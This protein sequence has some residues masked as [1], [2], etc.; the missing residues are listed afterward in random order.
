MATEAPAAPAA[1]PAAAPAAPPAPTTEIHVTPAAVDRGPTAP[2]PKSGSARERMFSDLRKKAGEEPDTPP[3]AT[4]KPKVEPDEAPGNEPTPG[5]EPAEAP[6]AGTPPAELAKKG[7]VS[8]WKLVEEHK[9]ARLKAENELVELRKSI[10]DPAKVKELE[11]RASDFEKRAKELDDHMKFVDYTRSQEFQ[12][13]YKKPYDDSW[14]KWMGELGELTVQDANGQERPLAPQDLLELV[15][16]PLQRAREEAESKFGNFADDVMAARKEIR[17]LFDSQNK[18]L[19]EAKKS[20]SERI[21]QMQKQHQES[22]E[23]LRKEITSV[24]EAANKS[25]TTDETLKKF[26][27]PVEGDE[28]GN[29]RL[30]KGYEMAD[31]AFTVNPNDSRL[32]QDQRAEVVRLHAAI[33]NRAAGFGRLAYQNAKL[34]ATIKEMTETLNK[35]KG[36][37][38]PAGEGHH[39]Q[40]A[41][42]ATARDSVF[43]ALR[44]LAH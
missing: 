31:R 17:G 13:K 34:E 5:A 14:Q 40:A 19:A 43:G 36:V 6:V 20:S 29:A 21:A 15:N 22:Q 28:D 4:A 16:L 37:Q 39:E 42:S 24:W 25:V 12:D 26:F 44:K 35:Y 30:Q 1:P 38:P 7:K 32:T 8:P 3:A 11:T 18:A 27:A 10:I 2:P 9:T 41:G 33:R 23:T